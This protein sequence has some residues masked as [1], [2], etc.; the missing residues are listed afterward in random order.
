MPD[1]G[2]FSL[3][4]LGFTLGLRHGID[5]DHI[6]AITDI[7]GSV[8]TIGEQPGG[9]HPG[10]EHPGGE[11][12]LRRELREGFFLA[13]MYALGHGLLVI[14]LGLLALW[15]G[16]ILP[17]W[18]DPIVE[19]VVGM[20]L[21]LLAVWILYSIGRDGRSFQLKSRWML[22]FS[23]I[24]RIGNR[25]KRKISG[26][27]I[28][29]SRHMQY[30]PRTAFSIGLIHGIG[31]ETGSQALLLATV[32]G[33]TTKLTASLLLLTFTIGLL[34]ANSLVAAFSLTS[35]G[36]VRTRQN[37]YMLLGAVAS[38]FSL[39]VGVCFVTGQGSA[40]P[41]SQELLNYLFG[42]TAVHL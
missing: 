3:L 2:L 35:F 28:K 32:A 4:S 31:A 21:I 29:P 15:L 18:L 17:D 33:A 27:P 39:F 22:I 9:S 40:L 5:W 23:L 19:R 16:A 24:G 20:T 1:F 42:K 6:A 26:R 13:T 10:G 41:D 38:I 36:S 7:T 8:M 34:L 37:I 30:G 12:R 11:H 25:L 14:V